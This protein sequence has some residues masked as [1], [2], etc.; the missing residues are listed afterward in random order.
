MDSTKEHQNIT[1]L[2]IETTERCNMRCKYCYNK[3]SI[4]KE[5]LGLV[6]IIQA[7][8]NLAEYKMHPHLILSGGE[9]L[10][11]N[12]YQEIINCLAAKSPSVTIA[13][14]GLLLTSET[15]RF[16]KR[17]DNTFI[18]VSL[19]GMTDE[20]NVYRGI[21]AE[22][23]ISALHRVIKYGMSKRLSIRVTIHKMNWHN[24][25]QIMLFCHQKDIEL[26][27]SFMCFSSE[28]PETK[29]YLL[30]QDEIFKTFCKIKEFN[31]CYDCDFQLPDICV[32]GVCGLM[33]EQGLL[34]VKIDVKGNVYA[35]QAGQSS[36]FLLGN[37]SKT[38]LYDCTQ[39]D[40]LRIIRNKIMLRNKLL[41]NK[42]SSCTLISDCLGRCVAHIEN[43]EGSF[44]KCSDR[45][46]I[47]LER[48]FQ[49]GNVK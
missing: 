28:K 10:M 34:A 2:Y 14:N 49:C 11:R 30:D 26:R 25:D 38:T 24:I 16:I 9:F 36:N 35:C 15:I 23:I 8:D 46:K 33:N 4:H 29:E 32:G 5:D 18:Q 13:T 17:L 1:M 45:Y 27:L 7:L 40:K 47:A 22:T 3:P 21:K 6:S 12:D 44:Y 19:D 39:P 20:D 42:C 48:Y 31:N 37:L 43:E 41:E